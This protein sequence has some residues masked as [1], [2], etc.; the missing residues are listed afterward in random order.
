MWPNSSS[1]AGRGSNRVGDVGWYIEVMPAA[2]FLE[3]SSPADCAVEVGAFGV[4]LA[5][6][7]Y[8]NWAARD[9][10]WGYKR[11]APRE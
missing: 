6:A 2:P 10:V 5:F 3:R 7:W 8:L 9:L 1:P 4:T 11:L